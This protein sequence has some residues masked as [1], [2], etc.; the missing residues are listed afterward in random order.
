MINILLLSF[1]SLGWAGDFQKA[2]CVEA[3]EAAVYKRLPALGAEAASVRTVAEF[4]CGEAALIKDL[5]SP[6][7]T[8][9]TRFEKVIDILEK[10]PLDFSRKSLDYATPYCRAES[11]YYGSFCMAADIE[12]A[13]DVFND[14]VLLNAIPRAVRAVARLAEGNKSIDLVKEISAVMP[15]GASRR[16]AVKLAGFLGLDDNGVQTDRLKADLL[17]AGR[18]EE[19]AAVFVPL[20]QFFSG[21]YSDYDDGTYFPVFVFTTRAGTATLPGVQEGTRKTYKAFAAMYL[22]CKLAGDGFSRDF[23]NAQAG[24]LGF[25]YEAIKTRDLANA[26]HYIA[27]GFKTAGLMRNAANYGQGLC[28]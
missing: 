26:G 22:G 4:D 3:A 12:A 11:G 10:L 2:A 21:H 5:D 17:W 23:I 16:Q 13:K 9:D 14:P 28:R 25:F 8:A 7:V 18:Y 27:E 20:S 1:V 19:Y 24:S 15:A 6:V